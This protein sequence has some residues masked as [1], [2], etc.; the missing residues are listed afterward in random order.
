M[1]GYVW[2]YQF[3]TDKYVVQESYKIT[4]FQ[5]YLCCSNLA[6]RYF[7]MILFWSLNFL[8]NLIIQLQ[9]WTIS[10]FESFIVE[11]IGLNYRAEKSAKDTKKNEFVADRHSCI[12]MCLR[13]HNDI[14]TLRY[15]WKIHRLHKYS[16]EMRA[17]VQYL[18][19]WGCSGM[20]RLN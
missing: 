8:S 19:H 1:H 2:T 17:P 3:Y 15:T 12:Y 20:W 16:G 5:V 18:C 6:L 13:V 10:L 4:N 14:S 7:Y 11:T 9:S